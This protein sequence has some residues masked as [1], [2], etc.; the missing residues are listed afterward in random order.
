MQSLNVAGGVLAILVIC[1]P[2]LAY[3]LWLKCRRE[4]LEALIEAED[5]KSAPGP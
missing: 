2:L 3:A 5:R 1:C 4:Q